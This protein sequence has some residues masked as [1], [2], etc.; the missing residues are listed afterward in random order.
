MSFFPYCSYKLDKRN[1]D[2]RNITSAEGSGME[3]GTVIH[4]GELVI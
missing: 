4:F 2:K 3:E 1:D